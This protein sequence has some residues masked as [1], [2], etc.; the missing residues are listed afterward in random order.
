[1]SFHDVRFPEDIA[2]GAVGGPGFDT[3][4][5]MLSSGHEKRNRNWSEARGTWDVAHG[6]KTQQQLDRLLAFFRARQGRAHAFRFKDWSDHRLERQAIGSGDGA[7]TA[8][9]LTK[10]YI[11]DGGYQ[12]VRRITRP[13]AGSVRVWVDGD[14]QVAGVI[15]E[16]SGGIVT[17]SVA[18]AVGASIEVECEFDVPARFDTDQMKVTIEDYGAFSWGQIPIVEV[19]E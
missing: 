8:F 7:T 2:V 17:F 13:V 18:P 16:H 10:V 1:M 12:A 5:V 9:P 6:L 14:E 4:V 3:A 11:D 19:R 15:T